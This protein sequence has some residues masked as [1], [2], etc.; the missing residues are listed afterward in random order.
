MSC[1]KKKSAIALHF[2][3]MGHEINNS[4]ILLKSVNR[5]NELITWEKIY[6][7]K[8]ADHIMNFE[9]L[10]ESW[11][12]SLKSMLADHQTAHW[13]H[14]PA[15]PQCL[16]Q[17]FSQF[18]TSP[19]TIVFKVSQLSKLEVTDKMKNKSYYFTSKGLHPFFWMFKNAL[20]K[21]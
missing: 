7:H 8:H 11:E 1:V 3:N 15:S 19:E 20:F 12:F 18:E 4:A 14:Q 9:V 13:W 5:K 6:L 21:M 2:W 10:P 16:I 17:H